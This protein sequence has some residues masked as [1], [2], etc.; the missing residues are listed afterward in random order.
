MSLSAGPMGQDIDPALRH[1]VARCE[2]REFFE[3]R[4]G[5]GTNRRAAD[6]FADCGILSCRRSVAV[7]IGHRQASEFGA[8]FGGFLL[9]ALA[10]FDALILSTIT[11]Q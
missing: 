11:G 1:F 5:G 2:F 3:R 10:R 6:P 8:A 7:R 9:A 4:S